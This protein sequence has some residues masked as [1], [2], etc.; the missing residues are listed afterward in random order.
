ML[1]VRHTG[2]VVWRRRHATRH[3]LGYVLV[4]DD[5]V[6]LAGTEADTG[7]YS[8]LSIPPDAIG[9]ARVGDDPGEQVV[10]KQAVVIELADDDPIYLRPLA[11]GP[12]ELEDLARKLS[13]VQEV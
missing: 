10:G 12:L 8:V 2:R 1:G 5:S 13:S 11:P 9:R 7:I 3:Y 4:D 6:R